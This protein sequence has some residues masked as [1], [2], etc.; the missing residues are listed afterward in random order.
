MCA[1]NRD[2]SY[3]KAGLESLEPYLLS[4]EMFWP[5]GE[6]RLHLTLGGMLLTG[7]RLNVGPI[8]DEWPALSA[9][10]DALRSRWRAAWE[11]KSGREFHSRIDLWRN[12]LQEVRE[13][14]DPA[15]YA[16]Q[17]QWRVMLQL[18]GSEFS[19]STQESETVTALDQILKSIWLPGIFVWDAGLSA[20]FPEQEY[21]Y[22]Y[23]RLK[24]YQ[25][26][27]P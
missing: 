4:N 22:L 23:G 5:L 14:S 15:Y 16:Q 21:W 27:L 18:L 10:L 11:R 13:G 25:E 1:L 17:V 19:V 24:L 2:L 6:D 12:Y 3:F 7:K 8:Q 9:R 20:A 26:E